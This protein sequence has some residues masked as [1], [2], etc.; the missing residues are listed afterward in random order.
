MDVHNEVTGFF[1][2][3]ANWGAWLL[4]RFS[5]GGLA[6]LLQRAIHLV[7]TTPQVRELKLRVAHAV[8]GLQR[9]SVLSAPSH[10]T[11]RLHWL[12]G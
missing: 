7:S 6:L 8:A 4:V 2:V 10:D 9:R 12:R 5:M 11:A 3:D 1:I